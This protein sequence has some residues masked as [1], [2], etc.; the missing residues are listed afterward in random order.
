[1][2]YHDLETESPER[3]RKRKWRALH[4]L[5]EKAW[6]FSNEFKTRMNDAGLSEKDVR[7]PEGFAAIPPLRK[8]D[9]IRLQAEHGLDWMLTREL[10]ELRHI[11]QSPGP[12][13]DPEGAD[14]DYWGWAEAFYAAGFR[15][16]DV[17]QMTFSYHLTPAGLMLEEP[18]RDIGCAVIPAGPGQTRT[19]IDIMT[20]LPVTGFVGMASFLR[21][22]GRKAVARGLDP[23]RDF[24]LRTAFVAAEK[25]TRSLR[26]EVEETFGV[27]VRQGYGTA[28]VG[29]IAYECDQAEGMHLSSRALVE[30]C[31]PGTG[32][33]LPP[34]EMGE[35][36]VTPFTGE[37]PL[38]RLATGDLSRVME[39]PCACGRTSFR[40]EGWLGRVDDTA[41]VKGQFLYPDQ[42]S[43]VMEQFEEIDCWQLVVANPDG[44]DTLTCRLQL[45]PDAEEL[46]RG[47]FAQAF[48]ECCKLR[49][50]VEII[51]VP[52]KDAT[53][54]SGGLDKKSPRLVDQRQFDS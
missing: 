51:T 7:T 27:T 28:D 52:A 21:T 54:E 23:R 46:D 42:A 2:Y 53:Q 50:A 40:L 29:C 22:I 3:R 37:Y 36:V 33:P 45:R 4:T 25:L 44:R 31:D 15:P 1:M 48:Q 32:Q 38:I 18:L 5:L 17:V 24:S 35:V 20:R 49:P 16:R 12:I 19:Q 43:T 6:L 47:K 26:T 39:E 30:I 10:G 41:K 13:L 9:I 14:S 8:K 11:Y 34:G